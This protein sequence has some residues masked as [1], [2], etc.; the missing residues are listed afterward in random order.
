MNYPNLTKEET[1]KLIF[2]KKQNNFYARQLLINHNLKIVVGLANEFQGDIDLSID[3][4]I[5]IGSLGLI[6]AVD[7]YEGNNNIEFTKFIYLNIRHEFSNYLDYL[8]N[9]DKNQYQNYDKLQEKTIPFNNDETFVNQPLVEDIV[10]ENL[11]VE[12]VKHLYKKL[13]K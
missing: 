8:N 7:T 5:N 3:E 1:E 11:E 4:L 2:E 6:E 10:L 13:S 12:N 9:I